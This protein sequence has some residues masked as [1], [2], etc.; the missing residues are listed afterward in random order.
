MGLDIN[1]VCYQNNEIGSSSET[2]EEIYTVIKKSCLCRE[3]TA[4]P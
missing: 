2:E 1:A 4:A 3:F